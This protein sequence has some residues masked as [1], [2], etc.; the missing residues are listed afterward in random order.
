MKKGFT[1]AEVLITLGIIG[2]VAAMTIPTVISNFQKKTVVTRLKQTY[3]QITTA[4][5]KIANENG[6]VG[7][8]AWQCDEGGGSIYWQERC[9]HE[10]MK[11][12]AVKLYPQPASI[13]QAAC[14]EG[15]PYKAYTWRNGTLPNPNQ[16]TSQA[17]W[18]AALPNGACV[19][20]HP[21]AWA[22]DLRG[23]ITIDVDGSYHGANSLGKDL[24]MFIYLT[25]D[26]G[27]GYG[28]SGRMI[29]P[30][31]AY[32]LDWSTNP[33]TLISSRTRNQL[34]DNCK[35]NGTGKDCAALIMQDGWQIKDD[36][37]W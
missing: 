14:Y 12:I 24:F 9:F 16:I 6:V 21:Y 11:L 36:Y 1:L 22:G 8:P 28:P 35:Q 2:V 3:A 10:A 17:S 7:F 37:P 13:E 15:T 25:P 29:I 31:G 20:W 33:G 26:R 30:H 32:D 4:V 27:Y 34:K 5:E 23:A 19:I 18:S